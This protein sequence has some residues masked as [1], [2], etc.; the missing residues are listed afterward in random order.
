[1]ARAEQLELF[2]GYCQ[3]SGVVMTYATDAD[4]ECV[5]VPSRARCAGLGRR[6]GRRGWPWC[7]QPMP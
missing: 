3:G 4:M 7:G 6:P 2:C 1:M 5:A